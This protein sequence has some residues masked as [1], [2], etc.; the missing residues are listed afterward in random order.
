ML[1]PGQ[2]AY[3][4]YAFF[5]WSLIIFDILYDSL[6]TLDLGESGMEASLFIGV[7]V[8]AVLIYPLTSRH[9]SASRYIPSTGKMKLTKMKCIL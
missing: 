2:L 9:P 1:T 8:H 6:T 5:E 4:R 3:T 7:S